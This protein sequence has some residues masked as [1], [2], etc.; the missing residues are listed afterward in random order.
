MNTI[1]KNTLHMKYKF[2]INN[3]LRHLF[4]LKYHLMMIRC[5]GVACQLLSIKSKYSSVISWSSFTVLVG[6][7]AIFA[8]LF[9]LSLSM[10]SFSVLAPSSLVRAAAVVVA[11]GAP[12]QNTVDNEVV[13]TPGTLPEICDEL[14]GSK[15]GH[16]GWD[17]K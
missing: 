5:P 3:Q 6:A 9:A 8:C 4:K 15:M 11:G 16:D 7:M 1:I 14:N 13:K 10:I 12:L 17:P 2:H